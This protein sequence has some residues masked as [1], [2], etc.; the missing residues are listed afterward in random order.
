MTPPRRDA[1]ERWLAR[2]MRD[3]DPVAI[4]RAASEDPGLDPGTRAALARVDPDGVRV[5]ALLVARLRFERLLAGSREAHE[6]FEADPQGFAALFRAYHREV[7]M[8]ASFP[9]AEGRSFAAW[10]ASRPATP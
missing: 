4:L 3:D 6:L 9:A 7:A 1:L 5:Q 2:A 10:R 8:G